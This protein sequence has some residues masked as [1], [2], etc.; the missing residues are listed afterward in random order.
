VTI[1]VNERQYAHLASVA[2]YFQ[3]FER[4]QRYRGNP[5]LLVATRSPLRSPHA[6]MY[7]S[8]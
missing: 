3:R 2:A 4:W 7:L 8:T 6:G 5:G 1:V